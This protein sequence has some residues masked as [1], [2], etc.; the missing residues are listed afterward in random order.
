[1]ILLVG[2]S[3]V[4]AV[5]DDRYDEVGDVG[6]V[7]VVAADV[8]VLDL[9]GM[10]LTGLDLDIVEVDVEVVDLVLQLPIFWCLIRPR[11]L[12]TSTPQSQLMPPT[13]LA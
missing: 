9:G 1:M 4:E 5:D 2:A 6:L 11:L 7:L 13:C 12:L 8:V 3:D 10:L